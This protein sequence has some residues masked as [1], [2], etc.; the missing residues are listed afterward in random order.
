MDLCAAK[1]F[2]P[3]TLTFITTYR[4]TAACAQCCFESSPTV[5][6]RLSKDEMIS[7]LHDVKSNFP[8][9][10]VVVFTGGEATLLKDDLV[11]VIA[12]ATSLGLGT[13]MVSNGSWAKTKATAKRWMDKLSKAGL[14]ELNISS[15]KD[16]QEWVPHE[17]VVN[18][19]ESSVEA[20]LFTLVT[21]E[22]DTADGRTLAAFSEDPLVRV[23]LKKG[24]RLQSNSWMA[25]KT[26][27]DARENA[28]PQSIR[29]APCD[30]IHNNIVITPYKEVAACCGL[31]LEHIPEMKLGH[32][33]D[34]VAGTYLSQADD[35]LKYWIKVDGPAE[36]IRRVMGEQKA[37]E[38]LKGSVHIC[39]D[40]AVLHKNDEV[41]AKLADEYARFVPDVMSRHAL[42]KAVDTL[43]FQQGA[44]K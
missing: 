18:A 32:M 19:A 33:Q 7:A 36:I 35:F 11:A 28:V 25:F 41:R 13:R 12:E 2:S 16:H 34:G 15:G 42:S 26:D 1:G 21:V 9:L 37:S 14:R 30:Q 39:H 44:F 5:R 27:H 3:R 8:S 4:C 40:C 22:A 10:S 31:T 24:L 23:L 17:S 20:G 6:G 29:A 38:L 43:A